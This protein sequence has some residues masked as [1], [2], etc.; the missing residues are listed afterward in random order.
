MPADLA[1]DV[2][3]GRK[4]GRSAEQPQTKHFASMTDP[5]QI[6]DLL[7]AMYSYQGSPVTLAVLKLGP[8]L[9]VRPGELR[10]ARWE[11][12]DIEKAEWRFVAS[13]TGAPHIVPLSSQ[14]KEI[15]EDLR[16]SLVGAILSSQG[17]EVR[18]AR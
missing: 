2:G 1:H 3:P 13:K 8:M 12:V 17:L 15:F 5:A 18:S 9:F 11:D 16:L 4:L 10:K 6:S 14:A 7:R